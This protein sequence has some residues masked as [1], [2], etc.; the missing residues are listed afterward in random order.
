M[1]NSNSSI[2]FR[3]ATRFILFHP[4]KNKSTIPMHSSNRAA[5]FALLVIFAASAIAQDA[6]GVAGEHCKVPDQ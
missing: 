5:V 4:I 3:Q 2:V 1:F 6:K